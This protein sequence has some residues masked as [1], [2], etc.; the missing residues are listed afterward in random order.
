MAG[1]YGGL[2]KKGRYLENWQDTFLIS[3]SVTADDVGKL[4]TLDATA[5][6]TVK[7]AGDGDEI[8]GRLEVF[9]NRVQEGLVVGTIATKFIDWV[10][11]TGTVAVGNGIQG[12]ATAG[13][14]KALATG[15]AKGNK[16]IEVDNTNNR[17]F[18][19]FQ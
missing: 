19:Y 15:Q 6:R 12:S 1:I 10:P 16:V 18:V 4:V 14:A 9:E 7:L 2:S 5:A 17:V 11:K 3:G 8:F 13:V